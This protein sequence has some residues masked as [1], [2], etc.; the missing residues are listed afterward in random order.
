LRVRAKMIKMIYLNNHTMRLVSQEKVS[1]R[2]SQQTTITL[3]NK[4]LNLK[5]IMM[6]KIMKIIMDNIQ[7]KRRHNTR[8]L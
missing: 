7:R 6:M 4:I 3:T 2:E 1:V 8:E 5:R